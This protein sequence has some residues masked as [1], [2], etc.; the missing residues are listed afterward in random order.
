MVNAALDLLLDGESGVWHLANSGETTCLEFIKRAAQICGISTTN[1]RA[2]IVSQFNVKTE[3][4]M[5]T[6]L[7]SERGVLLPSLEVALEQFRDEFVKRNCE[8]IAA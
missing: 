7:G 6:A 2:S 1:L 5:Y 4:P 3:C 8:D